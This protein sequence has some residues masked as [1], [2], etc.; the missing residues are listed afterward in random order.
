MTCDRYHRQTLLEGF[1]PERQQRLARSHAVVVGLG[2]V[3][4]PAADLLARAGV[5]HLTLIDRDLVEFTNL[6]RQSLFVE[7][8]AADALPKAAVAEARLGEANG[9]IEIISRVADVSQQ[10]IERMLFEGEAGRPDIVV[11]G[12]DNFETRYLLNDLAVKHGLPLIYAGAIAWRAM[13]MPVLPGGACLQSVFGQPPLQRGDTCDTVGVH[14]PAAAIAG[15]RAASL[16]LRLLA[17][18]KDE[19]V[20]F[21]FDTATG[22]ATTVP[23]ADARN[24]ECRCCGERRFDFLDGT[25]RSQ[26]EKLCGTE[27]VQVNAAGPVDIDLGALAARLSRFGVFQATR[28]HV[29]G[30][31]SDEHEGIGVTVFADGRAIVRG[32][33][34]PVVARGIYARYIGG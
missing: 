30:E 28:F 23:L 32:T 8:D 18:F 24:D 25:T 14:A 5:G 4:C 29:R 2:A 34:D 22:R 9:D 3:G 21:T 1:G 10:N 26:S 19:P 31:L 20:L 27:A 16:A 17:G 11:D 7:A 12:S 6:Q 33:S 13:V 15:S